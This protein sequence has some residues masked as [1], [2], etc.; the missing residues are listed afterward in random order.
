MGQGTTV[1]TR[2]VDVRLPIASGNNMC[3]ALIVLGITC[4]YKQADKRHGVCIL[5]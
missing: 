3:L 4:A 2:D 1:G 5:M